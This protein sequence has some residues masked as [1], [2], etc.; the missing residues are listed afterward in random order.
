MARKSFRISGAALLAAVC[1]LLTL[2]LAG[3]GEKALL[4]QP[5]QQLTCVSPAAL[6]T[7]LP[8]DGG[9]VL[10]GWVDY[11][12]DTTYLAVVDV[13]ADKV[14]QYRELE[15][16]WELQA[17]RF[18]DGGAAL[19]CW[20]E[21]GW[22]LIGSDLADWG[23]YANDQYGGVF[24]H[25]GSR[26]YFI[27]DDVLCRAEVSTGQVERVALEDDMRFLD[28][29][30]IA[31]NSET[32]FLHCRLSPYSTESGTAIV[33]ADT[34]ANAMLQTPW[35][36]PYPNGA[37]TELL[38]FNNEAMGYDV[39][40]PYD[41]AYYR[42]ESVVLGGEESELLPVSGSPYLLV[43][44]QDVTLYRLADGVS[45]C[46]LPEDSV[47]GA[48]RD[49][50]WLPENVLVGCVY[51][52]EQLH[53][54][55]IDPAQLTF[56]QVADAA[57]I[58]S[59]LTV[60]TALM[61]VYWSELNGAPLPA[62]LQEARD[63]ADRLEE[64]Y[65]VTILLSAQGQEACEAVWDATITTTDQWGL[66]D[67]PRA[68]AR[69][70]EALDRTLALYPEGFFRQMRNSMDEGGVRFIPVGHIENAVNAIGL[71]YETYGWQNIYIDVN[72][73]AFEGTI[74]HEIWHAIEGVLLTRNWDAID[75]EEWDGCNPEGFRY[76]EDAQEA[77][78]DPSR[79]TFFGESEMRNVYF[80]DN[81]SR[82]NAK[83][84]RARLMEYIMANEDVAGA[85]MQSPA[86][87]QKLEIMCRAIREN[88]DAAGWEQPRWERLL[89]SA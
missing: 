33:D 73:D 57:Q 68:I 15:G 8:L 89:P 43:V 72:I 12:K 70:L 2:A 24:S 44:A 65:G 69:M 62:T 23:R 20:E 11:E 61:E 36:A 10:T 47:G 66:E 81:Y 48:M 5:I 67:E 39:L 83:E 25:D 51:G 59:P 87:R 29:A 49:A 40:Y 21:G 17:Q 80:V 19:F 16:S 45:A 37:G 7:M 64:R 77:D 71:T 13:A 52:D 18:T 41:G 55:A 86:L 58:E 28:V 31:P 76:N 26:Y 46:P 38:W 6:P 4:K 53:L 54:V 63:Y 78:P 82:T 60:D 22:L 88:F 84:D 75:R 9:Q 56:T 14:V 42:A 50:V 1:L 74:C 85:L 32:L 35:Y 79:W 34:G 30:G 3:C 27:Q